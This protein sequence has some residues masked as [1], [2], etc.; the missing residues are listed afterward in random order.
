[1]MRT[2]RRK[3]KHTAGRGDERA[4]EAV[5]GEGGSH[6]IR[7]TATSFLSSFPS[8]FFPP[9]LRPSRF[10]LLL[11]PPPFLLGSFPPLPLPSLSLLVLVGPDRSSLLPVPLPFRLLRPPRFETL[12]STTT[13]TTL[14]LT[15]IDRVPLR[16]SRCSKLRIGTGNRSSSSSSSSRCSSEE[17]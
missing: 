11:P 12:L 9:Q 1:M 3:E 2:R 10:L 15:L 8:F 5:E 16:P 14:T 7:Q 17:P 4:E 13:T 6:S